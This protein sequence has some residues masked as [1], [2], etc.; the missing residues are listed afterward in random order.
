MSEKCTVPALQELHSNGSNA[1]KAPFLNL[2]IVQPA[3]PP[4]CSSRAHFML[5]KLNEAIRLLEKAK[6]LNPR[7]APW[8]RNFYL[9]ATKFYMRKYQASA[10]NLAKALADFPKHQSVN[11]YLAASL[12]MLGHQKKAKIVLATYTKLARG[13][14]DTIE[15][16]RTD[17]AHIEPNFDLLAAAL[18]R[19]GMPER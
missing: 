1:D 10:D 8:L 9:G 5:G 16:L 19:A 7:F 18:R 6:E 12:A 15:K 2:S 3:T 17:R 4:I 11:L 13:K 14:R